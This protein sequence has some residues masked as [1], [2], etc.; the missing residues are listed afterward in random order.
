M[1]VGKL[2]IK[3]V[4]VFALSR[5]KTI[6]KI[7]RSWDIDSNELRK[8]KYSIFQK[9]LNDNITILFNKGEAQYLRSKDINVPP[10]RLVSID[11]R[12]ERSGS[13]I[14]SF[15]KKGGK[16]RV[17][18]DVCSIQS[19]QEFIISA[20]KIA[21][22]FRKASFWP[23]SYL[24]VVR[25]SVAYAPSKKIFVG[26]LITQLEQGRLAEDTI[27]IVE[28]LKRGIM[29]DVVKKG[30]IYPHVTIH[31][32]KL[33]IELKAKTYEDSPV[34]AAYFYSF[35]GLEKPQ[36]AVEILSERYEEYHDIQPD[37]GIKG[38]INWLEEDEKLVEMPIVNVEIDD[39]RIKIPLEDID[40][41]VSI[42]SLGKG[43]KGVLIKG[44]DIKVKLGDIDILQ[45]G[46][47]RVRDYKQ[48]ID[49]LKD[50]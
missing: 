44:K 7:E 22:L 6:K 18:D 31:N 46:T 25:F 13:Y 2:S 28:Q 26:I 12:K 5:E 35:L 50:A 49:L 37:E 38:L 36:D 14:V 47:I 1:R 20:K 39:I 41:R 17:L 30:L 43:N 10:L 4:G 29:G 21:H 8:Q 33:K 3:N 11:A 15:K 32:G 40:K 24:F 42:T 23:K 19:K 27:K 34:P 16:R 9:F 48:L 45:D